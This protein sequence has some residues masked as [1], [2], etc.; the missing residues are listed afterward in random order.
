M[1]SSETP[2]LIFGR[3]VWKCILVFWAAIWIFVLL[4][5]LF[6]KGYYR[7]YAELLKRP[8]LEEKHSYVTGEGLYEMVSF[9][10]RELPPDATFGYCG[11]RDNWL[12]DRRIRYYLYPRLKSDDPNFLIVFRAPQPQGGE[13]KPFR[14]LDDDRYILARIR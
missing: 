10:R 9:A 2:N 7:E 8:T 14:R 12:D 13:W 5:N 4:K 3:V 6:L 1:N 11:I